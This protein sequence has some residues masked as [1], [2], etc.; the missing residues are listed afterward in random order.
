MGL[1]AGYRKKRREYRHKREAARAEALKSR[2]EEPIVRHGY[3]RMTDPSGAYHSDKARD[4][5]G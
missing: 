5:R 3:D 2:Q 4:I 1:L